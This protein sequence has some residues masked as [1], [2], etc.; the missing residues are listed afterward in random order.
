MPHFYF[1]TDGEGRV[2]HIYRDGAPQEG[3][4]TLETPQAVVQ[5]YFSAALRSLRAMNID[6]LDREL[7]DYGLQSFVMSLTGLE[8]FVNVYFHRRGFAEGN[9]E[10]M[11]RADERR[12]VEHKLSHLP[13]LAFGSN[14]PDQRMLNRKVRELYSLRSTIVHPKLE[15]SSMRYEN[16]AINGMV[17]NFQKAF[18]DPEF[19]REALQWCLLIVGRVGLAAQEMGDMFVTYWTTV[20]ECDATLSGALGI[21]AASA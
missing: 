13:R 16:I 20:R 2:A 10:L 6:M 3:P 4:V 14:L 11:R 21:S 19:C 5:S 8:A 7:R 1:E 9:A 12:P 15:L 17:Q 18:E